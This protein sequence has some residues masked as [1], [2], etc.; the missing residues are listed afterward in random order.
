MYAH[1]LRGKLRRIVPKDNDAINETWIADRDR[2]GCFGIYA[3]DR[4]EKPM[5]KRDHEWF[6]VSWQEALEFASDAIRTAV[7]GEGESLGVLASP[8]STLEE[9]YLLGRIASHLGSPNVDHRLRRTDFRDQENDPA[10]PWLGLA[11]AEIEAQQGILVVGSNLRMEVPII[12]H[13]V[14]KAAL[15]GA[16][17]G[18]VNPE[19]YEF[20]F[21][22]AA[23]VEAA[24]P[25]FASV[26]AGVLVAAAKELNAELP[27]GLASELQDI[28]P[29]P[30]HLEAAR[31]LL[32]RE[33]TWIALGQLALRHPRF[34]EIRAIAAKLSQLTGAQLGYLPEGA[35]AVG[36]SLVG[37]LPHRDVGGKPTQSAGFHTQGMLA[38]P[39]HAYILLGLEPEEDIAP[40]AL[41]EGAL[42]SAD[43]VVALTP[44]ASE[45][46]LDCA[47]VLLPI[48]TYAETAGT[49]VNVEGSWQSFSAAA[50]CVGDARPGW[51][52]LRVFGNHFGLENCD[53][54]SAE[55]VRGAFRLELGTVESSNAYEG[56]PELQMDAID[57]DLS[58]IDVPIYS[59]D[60]IVRRSKPLQLTRVALEG[61]G[62]RDQTELKSA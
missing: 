19:D 23:F 35:N 48:G 9:L 34:T 15:A 37:F 10:W 3:E 12:A 39:R 22:Q 14:R 62:H 51:R 44:Y 36:A 40:A 33:R 8:N 49:F 27:A 6:E 18:F 26:L 55:E 38:S 60:A 59:V 54:Q 32:G 31:V 42:Q 46:L 4:L 56:T 25:R 28:V 57:V 21:S 11:I 17:V 45:S 24:L 47:D 61:A 29:L 20:H 41:A 53:Y 43:V 1:V 52:V 13:H 2:F 50:D 58:T 16:H 30:E 5:I 7:K